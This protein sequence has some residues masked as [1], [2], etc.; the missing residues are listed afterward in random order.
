LLLLTILF[1]TAAIFSLEAGGG[2]VRLSTWYDA[3]WFSVYSLFAGEPIPHAPETL[4]GKFVSTGIM[5]MGLTIFAM[6]T[7]TVSAFMV[8]RL[9]REERTVD[10]DELDGHVI[11]CGWSRKGE[12]IVRE[13]RHAEAGP[14]N[15]P[16]SYVIIA[17]FEGN[18]PPV[19]PADLSK[20]VF[21]LS[22]D[23][24]RVA[25]LE[26]AG[27]LRA[28]TCI[29][30]SDTTGTRSEQ[31]ADARTILAALTVEKLNSNVYTCAE[32]NNR[33]YGSH[34]EMGHVN[35]YV[36]GGEQSA[37]LLAQAA[38]NRGLMS[39]VA[40]LLTQEYGNQFYRLDAPDRWAGRTFWELFQEVKQEHDAILVAVRSADGT[41]RTNPKEYTIRSGDELILIAERAPVI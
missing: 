21:F 24:T 32:I 25:A 29:I 9:R 7:G 30:L 39:V 38:I 4:A 13:L 33:S 23:F 1:G 2:N 5:F 27:I 19:L 26:T 10:F 15:D 37:Y 35:D 41:Q 16:Q 11:I 28:K 40:E 17:D 34:L 3:F 36:V 22:D 31:D 20:H 14:P 18:K 12:I 8:D 6:F